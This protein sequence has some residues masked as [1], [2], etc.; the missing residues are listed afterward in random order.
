ATFGFNDALPWPLMLF[1][2]LVGCATVPGAFV[3]KR[4]L[5]AM[6]VRLHTVMREAVIVVGGVAVLGR[7]LAGG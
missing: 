5:E 7:G 1:A 4:I 6:P 2:L 3:A